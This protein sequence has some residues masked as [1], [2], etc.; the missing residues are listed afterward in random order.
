[1]GEEGRAMAERGE[2]SQAAAERRLAD[3]KGASSRET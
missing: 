2:C 1:M 3:Q